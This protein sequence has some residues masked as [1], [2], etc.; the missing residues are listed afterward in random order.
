MYDFA[1]SLEVETELVW[2]AISDKWEVRQ[3]YREHMP[4]VS[5]LLMTADERQ[6]AM[7]TVS[8]ICPDA[9]AYKQ[10]CAFKFPR[11]DASTSSSTSDQSN[12]TE[13]SFEVI[14]PLA[15]YFSEQELYGMHDK[16]T[17]ALKNNHV[18]DGFKQRSYL[19]E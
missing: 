16:A 10:C 19:V 18:R 17:A 9:R 3:E 8:K 15:K 11:K 7:K 6:H 14:A 12:I 1:E 5:H 4:R 2:F 13:P